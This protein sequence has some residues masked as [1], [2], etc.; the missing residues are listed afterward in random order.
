MVKK[1]RGWRG[2]TRKKLRQIPSYR[3]PITK[4]LQ[5]FKEGQNVV[6][7]P[8][9][10]SHKGMPYPRFKGKMGKV[11]EIRGK[12]YVVEIMDGNLMKKVIARPEHLK[13]L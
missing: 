10:S 12:S 8:E 2:S 13:A 11:V 6:I 9:P 1:S 7:L 4:F 5:E 3:P